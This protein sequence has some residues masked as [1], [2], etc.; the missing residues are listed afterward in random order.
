M[1]KN[2]EKVARV[3][4]TNQNNYVRIVKKIHLYDYFY[5]FGDYY[6]KT[7]AEGTKGT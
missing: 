4:F 2:E 3:L 7:E 6:G 1:S 5:L